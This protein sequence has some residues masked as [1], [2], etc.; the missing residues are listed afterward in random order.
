M[1]ISMITHDV[2]TGRLRRVGHIE[3]FHPLRQTV[4]LAGNG[5]RLIRQHFP[6]TLCEVVFED[7]VFLALAA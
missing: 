3:V 1:I 2:G 5:R 7:V 6:V 4:D